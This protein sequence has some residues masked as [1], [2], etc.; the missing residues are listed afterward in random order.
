MTV[1]DPGFPNMNLSNTLLR[2]RD[3]ILLQNYDKQ[4]QQVRIPRISDLWDNEKN[5]YFFLLLAEISS[6]NF[7][8]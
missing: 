6:Q 5:W 2:G 1:T 8:Y 7:L 4:K 3:R